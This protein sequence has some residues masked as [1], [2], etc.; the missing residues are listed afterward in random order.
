MKKII[1]ILVGFIS[2][3]NH[4]LAQQDPHFT[5]FFENTLFVNPAYAG[6]KDV[7]NVTAL[8]R[9]QWVGFAGRPV[10]TTMSV[11]SPLSYRS[12]GLGLT[13]V[14]DH[15]GPVDQIQFY[16]D[17]SYS[18]NFKNKSKL[19]FGIKGGLNMINIGSSNLNTTNQ[20]DPNL[21]LNIRNHVNPNFG[22]GV[23][24]HSAIWFAGVSTPRLLEQSYD[25]SSTNKEKR[26]YFA[27]VGGVFKVSNAWKV[28][29]IS[30][31]K[32]TVGA[33]LS[34]DVSVAGIY[35][36]RFYIGALYRLDAAIGAF[37]QYQITPQ[38]KLG[39]ATDFG[40]Q[41][42]RNYN[43]G[44]FEIMGSYDFVFKKSGVRSP[45]YF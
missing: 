24:Y 44:T 39:L 15:N 25:G 42:I 5:Q 4:V 43:Y 7:L 22:F 45:R 1:I 40:T 13:M 16:G 38:F 30:Q 35:R 33:P 6:S 41:E 32:L 20:N 27:N 21:I 31:L 37:V 18:L 29:P 17:F 2:C 34:L 14:N 26:H 9:E 10:S 28:R 11:H 3:V 23:Y 36:D 8:H 19:A 12:V